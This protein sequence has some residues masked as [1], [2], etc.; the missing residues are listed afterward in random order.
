MHPIRACLGVL[1]LAG[2]GELWAAPSYVVS[3]QQPPAVMREFRGAWV[4]SVGNIDWPSDRGL[5]AQQQRAELVA[6]LD[7]AVALKLNAILLQVRPASDALYASSL[8]P[9]SEYLSGEQGRGPQPHYDPLEFAVAEAHRRGIELHAWFNPFR[10][11]HVSGRSSAPSHITRTRPQLVRTYGKLLWLDP[12]EAAVHEHV[13]RVVLDV[14]NRYDVDGVHLDDYF[15][16]YPEKNSAGAW[17][18]FPDDSTFRRYAGAGGKLAH[19]DWRRENVNV[20]VYR[21]YSAVKAAKP[22]VK[23]GISPFGIWRNG[24][25]EGT[26]GLDAYEALYADSRRWLAGGWLDY[27]APQ[28]YWTIDSEGQ[29]FAALLKWWSGQNPQHR[30]LWPGLS[31]SGIG[32]NR[33]AQEIL[34]QVRVTRAQAGAGGEIHWSIKPLMQNR[35]SIA[36]RLAKEL[37]SQP[38]LVPASPWLDKEPPLRPRLSLG[39]DT[40]GNL[41]VIWS[42]DGAEKPRSWVLQSKFGNAWRTDVFA[43]HQAAASFKAEAMPDVVSVTAVDRAGN[44]SPPAVAEKPR[45]P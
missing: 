8:E 25:P 18:K 15:Y 36:D 43:A 29:S 2:A 33:R 17:M 16:P 19:A 35:D 45:V 42:A 37:Y 13:T 40:T 14:V 7:R 4:A 3:T 34:D 20:F 31:T 41:V 30:H 9:W 1:A 32:T 23:V 38:A 39:T 6:I 11:Q 5:P 12:G 10:A 21:L 24:V 44:A 22:W 27:C 26:R 28:L